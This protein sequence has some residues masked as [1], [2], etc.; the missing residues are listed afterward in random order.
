MAGAKTLPAA[1]T[2]STLPA[3]SSMELRAATPLGLGWRMV[4]DLG[5]GSVSAATSGR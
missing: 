5:R 1:S 2:E 4:R 3:R